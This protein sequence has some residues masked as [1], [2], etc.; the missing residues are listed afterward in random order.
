MINRLAEYIKHLFRDHPALLITVLYLLFTTVGLLLKGYLFIQ[1]NLNIVE[2]SEINDFLMASLYLVPSFITAFFISLII[3]FIILFLD[4]FS[5]IF[6]FDEYENSNTIHYLKDVFFGQNRLGLLFVIASSILVL[7]PCF[8][9]YRIVFFKSIIDVEKVEPSF[10]NLFYNPTPY[11]NVSIR[12]PINKSIAL[13]N[14]LQLIGS[15]EKYYFFYHYETKC[16]YIVPSTNITGLTI[17]KKP[18]IVK[19]LDPF[20]NSKSNDL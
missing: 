11:Y 19:D 20:K 2:Y 9:L 14:Y 16:T 6:N 3:V 15:T 18:D 17:V 8:G 4:I 13:P 5:K 7:G 10:I 1:F 12:F